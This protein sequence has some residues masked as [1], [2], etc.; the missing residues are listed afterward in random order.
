MKKVVTMMIMIPILFGASFSFGGEFEKI[1]FD[2]P[3]NPE[4][5]IMLGGFFTKSGTV[6]PNETMFTYIDEN[7]KYPDDPRFFS[8]VQY[9]FLGRTG[10]KNF[11]ISRVEK[12]MVLKETSEKINMYFDETHLFPLRFSPMYVNCSKDDK[13]F[14]KMIKLQGNQLEYQIILPNCLVEKK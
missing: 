4:C 2:A 9:K 1:E 12:I 11:E 7:K 3:K 5:R 10:E 6:N 13:A 8:Y 14:L